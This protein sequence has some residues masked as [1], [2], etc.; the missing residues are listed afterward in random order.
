MIQP[1]SGRWWEI[2]RCYDGLL[3]LEILA[4]PTFPQDS[5][6]RAAL[7]EA[8]RLIDRQSGGGLLAWTKLRK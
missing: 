5:A 3:R 8:R 1:V 6:T 7:D 4:V 2:A